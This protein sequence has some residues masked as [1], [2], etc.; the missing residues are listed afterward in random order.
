M[1]SLLKFWYNQCFS[2]IGARGPLDQ[3]KEVAIN[4]EIFGMI[5]K[6]HCAKDPR[7]S[8]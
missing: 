4:N 3:L 8:C 7:T 1:I 5:P 2:W 6:N